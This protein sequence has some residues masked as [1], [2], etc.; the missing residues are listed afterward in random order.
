[1]LENDEER[2][3]RPPS[4]W[5]YPPKRD[6]GRLPIVIYAAIVRVPP[7]ILDV[8]GGFHTAEQDLQFLLIEHSTVIRQPK[9]KPVSGDVVVP[10]PFRVNHL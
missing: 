1:M 6:N 3:P 7:Q 8:D 2:C 4:P 10:E 5:T 9:G